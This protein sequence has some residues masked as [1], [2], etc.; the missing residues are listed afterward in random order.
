MG[1]PS[2]IGPE[3]VVKA[4]VADRPRRCVV[5]GCADVIRAST[6]RFAPNLKVSV[7]SA[8]EDATGQPDRVEVLDIGDMGSFRC[9]EVSAASGRAAFEAIRDGIAYARSGQAAG[10]VT[11][12]IHKEALAAAGI[13]YPGH[14]EIL[15]DLVDAHRVVT[16]HLIVRLRRFS[17]G[18]ALNLRSHVSPVS[19]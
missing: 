12:P 19:N 16:W 18:W 1:D 3:I 17:M 7:L 15:A 10:L 6:E 11:A 9:G 13:A 2:G 4:L 8:I 14:T 5:I